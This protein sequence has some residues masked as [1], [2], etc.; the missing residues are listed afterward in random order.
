MHQ[1]RRKWTPNMLGGVLLPRLLH[2]MPNL[3]HSVIWHAFNV[4]NMWIFIHMH[5]CILYMYTY[6][7]TRNTKILSWQMH[8]MPHS[9]VC[10]FACKES[11]RTHKR[12][13]ASE[14]S[15]S[16]FSSRICVEKKSYVCDGELGLDYALFLT[17]WEL[18]LDYGE[19]PRNPE[20]IL[21]FRKLKIWQT[22]F[23]ISGFLIPEM[24][25]PNFEFSNFRIPQR[26]L[27]HT[28]SA[29]GAQT[30]SHTVMSIVWQLTA[31]RVDCFLFRHKERTS[32]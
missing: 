30:F 7:D 28:R 4:N 22:H 3:V 1:S 9:F 6:T 18:G 24:S 5:S 21:K 2:A 13:H 14:P 12:T 27:P 16:C 23:R 10:V 29:T 20:K 31:H 8:V 26:W 19:G 11:T 25:L 32:R 15:N 17:A